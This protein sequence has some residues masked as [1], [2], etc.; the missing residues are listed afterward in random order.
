MPVATYMYYIA[1][2]AD[3]LDTVFFILRKK[4]GHVSFLHIYHHSLMVGAMYVAV[5]FLPGGHSWLLAFINSLVHVVMYAY[6]LL[7]ARWP[8]LPSLGDWKRLVTQIQMVCRDGATPDSP[9]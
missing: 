7:A 2:I 5:N 8:T 6:Y 4:T 3:L 9:S 1:K